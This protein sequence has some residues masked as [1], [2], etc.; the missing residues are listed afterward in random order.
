MMAVAKNLEISNQTVAQA[1][2]IVVAAFPFKNT[3]KSFQID[4]RAR[5]MSCFLYH[6]AAKGGLDEVAGLARQRGL[7]ADESSG[8]FT[9]P[10]GIIVATIYDHADYIVK[11]VHS[12]NGQVTMVAIDE[13]HTL[14]K[15]LEGFRMEAQE[16]VTRAITRA[17]EATVVALS[18]TA[19]PP[20]VP[21]LLELLGCSAE[22]WDAVVVGPV[23]NDNIAI[24]V[25]DSARVLGNSKA[26][27]ADIFQQRKSDRYYRDAAYVH[28]LIVTMRREHRKGAVLVC[29]PQ[30]VAEA[31]A[32]AAWLHILCDE[33][34]ALVHSGGQ[35]AQ[36]DSSA[37]RAARIERSRLNDIA[38]ESFFAGESTSAGGG[39]AGT[40]DIIVGTGTIAVGVNR[41]GIRLTVMIGNCK[42]P[43][44]WW[45]LRGR[46]AR[47]G[48]PG[49]FVT[50]RRVTDA[51]QLAFQASEGQTAAAA[52]MALADLHAAVSMLRCR[53]CA[54]LLAL[55]SIGL[56]APNAIA[57]GCGN[58]TAC[59]EQAVATPAQRQV[60][61]RALSSMLGHS[62][63]LAV[64]DLAQAAKEECSQTYTEFAAAL[65]VVATQY[66]AFG[67]FGQGDGLLALHTGTSATTGGRRPW[68]RYQLTQRARLLLEKPGGADS[69]PPFIAS[70][71]LEGC[72]AV[73][74]K[75]S[76]DSSE[77]NCTAQKSVCTHT[78]NMQLGRKVTYKQAKA[79]EAAF[80]KVLLEEYSGFSLAPPP[81]HAAT[82]N[83]QKT[84]LD[85]FLFQFKKPNTPQPQFIGNLKANGSILGDGVLARAF[86]AA[87]AS[88]ASVVAAAA[89]GSASASAATGGG[90][91]GGSGGG[92]GG[93]VLVGSVLDQA[94][95]THVVA[96][97]SADGGACS[98]AME[99]ALVVV[100]AP[101]GGGESSGAAQGGGGSST[102]LAVIALSA[103]AGDG[104]GACSAS[105]AGDIAEAT[106]LNGGV[107]ASDASRWFARNSIHWQPSQQ[108]IDIS[109]WPSTGAIIV[110]GADFITGFPP[111]RACVFGTVAV[112][113]PSADGGCALQVQ[114]ASPNASWSQYV[115]REHSSNKGSGGMDSIS[116]CG[117]H[118]A[119]IFPA[120]FAV[121]AT[122]Q[123]VCCGNCECSHGHATC[124][125][126]VKAKPK[127]QTAH[128][129]QLLAVQAKYATLGADGHS[130]SQP[131]RKQWLDNLSDTE[132]KHAC[133]NVTCCR[134]LWHKPCE[135]RK[136][137][138]VL[139]DGR[140]LVAQT[141]THGHSVPHGDKQAP[142]LLAFN[143]KQKAQGGMLLQ[144][145]L[146]ARGSNPE[147]KA[148]SQDRK[149]ERMVVAQQAKQLF[150]HGAG[151]ANLAVYAKTLQKSGW[152]VLT[153]QW[154]GL[155]VICVS[156]AEARNLLANVHE[157]S[158]LASPYLVVDGT[159]AVEGI[160]TQWNVHLWDCQLA[161]GIMGCI[162][163]MNRQ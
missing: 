37:Q 138:W 140:V 133:S 47:D 155:Q 35:Q 100:P 86:A 107:I 36:G 162:M 146:G 69:L 50:L 149:L 129:A 38:F 17:S 137:R 54:A 64:T 61:Y 117:M 18:A 89:A 74:K 65:Q 14:P 21:R 157:G 134:P 62:V 31:E 1:G 33:P 77:A 105:G 15:D 29:C 144:Q 59:A 13:A 40:A 26:K 85:R 141:G 136:Y 111:R 131:E 153:E 154:G 67:A 73:E 95:S 135:V 102:A 158:H 142:T 112:N 108:P 123:Y 145:M 143:N 78:Y 163:Y 124:V 91:G 4:A 27:A 122:S 9:M 132:V 152:D 68:M 44:D 22:K 48:G 57:G 56:R 121:I 116:V 76:R 156:K 88:Y 96:C 6:A 5:G 80:Y 66:P 103:A 120:G 127:S 130:L 118:L 97:A 160:Y 159:F 115:W 90:D 52:R 60:I 58:C 99:S 150:P 114:C 125:G 81:E 72:Y 39:A 11:Y 84:G 23:Y 71:A 110:N 10:S 43:A 41:A 55:R 30:H 32:I 12:N 94:P 79:A 113:P 3:A 24:E 128:L 92:V 93:Q 16:S 126:D 87:K 34:V 75:P 20:M 28:G 151:Y 25:V 147:P 2:D 148:T 82:Y 63:P 7:F 101:Q 51:T 49:L 53:S 46:T 83:R 42:S 104:G 19:A 106:V 98:A 161:R 109:T 119:D 139:E 8:S 70:R 45:Q